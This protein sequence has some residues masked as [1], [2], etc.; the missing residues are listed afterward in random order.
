M[1][2]ELKI[3]CGAC[4]HDHA[5]CVVSSAS[6]FCCQCVE[7]G[8]RCNLHLSES[9]WKKM[10]LECEQLEAQLRETDDQL[11]KLLPQQICLRRQLGC[12]SQ[13][14]A[15]AICRELS[16]IKD[17][18]SLDAQEQE[19]LRVIREQEASQAAAPLSF[20]DIFSSEAL[21]SLKLLSPSDLVAAG[22][23]G[24][25]PPASGSSQG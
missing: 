25:N 20:E 4:C 14:E 5:K 23:L 15:D 1:G 21:A 12:L 9:E 18:E 19:A 6:S 13:K 22:L 17:Q 11:S 24:G 7:K 2:K 8:C 16:A 10:E 3:A